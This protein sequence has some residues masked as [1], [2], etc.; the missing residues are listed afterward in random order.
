MIQ[1]YLPLCKLCYLQSMAGKVSVLA[2]RDGLGNAIFNS[3]TKRLE[4]G[5]EGG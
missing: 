3:T 1:P 5:P 4:E 2:L